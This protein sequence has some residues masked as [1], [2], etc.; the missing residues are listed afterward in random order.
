MGMAEILRGERAREDVKREMPSSEEKQQMARGKG[1]E[2][3]KYGKGGHSD[4]SDRS[5]RNQ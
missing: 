3:R 4:T 5:R 2:A 1:K